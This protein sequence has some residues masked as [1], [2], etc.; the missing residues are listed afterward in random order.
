MTGVAWQSKPKATPDPQPVRPVYFWYQR[1]YSFTAT[2]L[3]T[4][5]PAKKKILRGA[6]FNFRNP[7][8]DYAAGLLAAQNYVPY[9]GQFTVA[10]DD[11]GAFRYM[12]YAMNFS[13]S[14]AAHGFVRA[15]VTEEVIEIGTGQT[16]VFLGAPARFA[17]RELVNRV[18]PNPN[19]QIIYL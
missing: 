10:E 5:Y 13:N 14:Q 2:I 7:P 15:M 16:T 9:Q 3:T 4:S 17:Y 12:A 6:D 8:A 19:D 18:R 1:P 11:A